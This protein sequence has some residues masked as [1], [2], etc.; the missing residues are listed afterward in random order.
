MKDKKVIK[1]EFQKDGYVFI[2]DF[3]TIDEVQKIGQNFNRVLKD[4]VPNMPQKDVF[5]E[6]KDKENV[7]T[8]KQLSELQIHDQFFNDVLMSSMFRELAELL[9]EDRVISKNIAYFNKP[10]LIGKPTPPHQDGYYFMLNP[11]VA[12]TMWMPLEP[13]DYENGCVKY[14]KGSHLK[15]MRPHLRTKTLGFSQG[16]IDFGTDD[17][18]N[19]V[20]F[21]SKPGDL[22]VHH[23]LTIHRAEGNTSDTRSRKALGLIYYGESAKEDIVAQMEYQKKL[24]KERK[25]F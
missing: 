24:Q 22:L 16:I 11:S 14:V 15:G 23:S 1:E 25:I 21:P 18:A 4:V 5:Y 8:L 19:E 10:P 3:L 2:P 17:T 12:L 6:D 7:S 13:V 9:L 20:S